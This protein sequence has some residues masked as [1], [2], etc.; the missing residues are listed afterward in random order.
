MLSAQGELADADAA[1]VTPCCPDALPA[2][3]AI[4]DAGRPLAVFYDLDA[5]VTLDALAHGE[6]VAW[7]DGKRLRDYDLVLSCTGGPALQQLSAAL[8]ARRVRALDQQTSAQRAQQLIAFL[9]Q[10]RAPGVERA[11]TSLAAA[12]ICGFDPCRA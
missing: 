3:A 1:I 2:R 8:G 9:E 5:P 12:P 11:S 7:I 6:R 4:L 10:A